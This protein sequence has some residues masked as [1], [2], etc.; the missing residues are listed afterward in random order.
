MF[1]CSV[2]TAQRRPTAKSATPVNV[3]DVSQA[4]H[5]TSSGEYGVYR[6]SE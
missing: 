4:T 1:A 6:S 5:Y 3:T 2:E